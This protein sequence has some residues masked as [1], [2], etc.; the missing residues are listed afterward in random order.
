MTVAE[1]RGRRVATILFLALA[2]PFA[3]SSTYQ[4]WRGAFV[5]SLTQLEPGA[6]K[7]KLVGL[8]QAVERAERAASS[9]VRPEEVG[10][11]FSADLRP[12]W[13]GAADAEAACRGVPHGTD[14]YAAV[15]RL[16][17]EAETTSEHRT[18]SLYGTRGIVQNL[19]RGG[20]GATR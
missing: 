15:V 2:I 5:D 14:A 6:C 3:V 8:T 13:D 17:A 20:R 7:D 10:A 16:R 1:R 19:L 18:E 4:L 9:K 12:E 11:G